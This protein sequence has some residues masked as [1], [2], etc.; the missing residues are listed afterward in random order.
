VYFEEVPVE[1]TCFLLTATLRI[2]HKE[3]LAPS[4]TMVVQVRFKYLRL[5]LLINKDRWQHKGGSEDWETV[6]GNPFWS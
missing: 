4:W 3:N 2:K 5:C 6:Q 1:N